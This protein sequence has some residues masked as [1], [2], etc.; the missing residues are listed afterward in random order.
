MNFSLNN[1]ELEEETQR[2]LS[3]GKVQLEEWYVNKLVGEINSEL[4]YKDLMPSRKWDF[5]WIGATFSLV[6]I[7]IIFILYTFESVFWKI[8]LPIIALVIAIVGFFVGLY[9]KK[10]QDLITI[11]TL[12][13]YVF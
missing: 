2:I 8:G 7:L 10:K 6:V 9:V 13:I 3:N 11:E 1:E 5:F 4:D 12:V